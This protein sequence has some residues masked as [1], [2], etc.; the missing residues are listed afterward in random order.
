[1]VDRWVHRWCAHAAARRG[2]VPAQV[3]GYLLR[4]SF[5]VELRDQLLDEIALVR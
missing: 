3:C 5:R 1:M 4:W 2:E